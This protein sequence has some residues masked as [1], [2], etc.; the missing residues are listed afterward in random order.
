MVTAEHDFWFAVI[1]DPTILD[2]AIGGVFTPVT[3]LHSSCLRS[4]S[5]CQRQ[6]NRP[7]IRNASAHVPSET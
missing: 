1:K 5:F 6:K 2:L 7:L 3:M 4:E